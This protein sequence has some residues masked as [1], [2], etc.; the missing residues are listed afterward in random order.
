MT[1]VKGPAGCCD[2]YK[3]VKGKIATRK[4]RILMGKK[5]YQCRGAKPPKIEVERRV[6]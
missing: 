5:R 2:N 6:S 1:K 4:H 3:K